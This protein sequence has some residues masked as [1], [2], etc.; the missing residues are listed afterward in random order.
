[1]TTW[2][3]ASLRFDDVERRAFFGWAV[4]VT[5]LAHAACASRANDE[6]DRVTTRC[7]AIVGGR[8]ATVA[9]Q[10]SAVAVTDIDGTQV[11]TGVLIAPTV[12]VT[13]AHCTVLQDSSTGEVIADLEPEDLSVVAG[14]LT[15]ADVRVDQIFEIRKIVTHPQFTGTIGEPSPEGLGNAHDIALLLLARPVIALQPTAIPSLGMVDAVLAGRPTLTIMGYGAT[16]PSG[17]RVGTLQIGNTTY[18]GRDESEFVAGGAGDAD[19]CAGDSGGPAYSVVEEPWLIGI[20]VRGRPPLEQGCGGGGVYTLLPA[21]S[22]WL[23]QNANGEYSPPSTDRASRTPDTGCE[24]MSARTV[25][26][27]H[28][29]RDAWLVAL[30]LVAWRRR[31]ARTGPAP[32]DRR[33]GRA[34]LHALGIR[35]RNQDRWVDGQGHASVRRRWSTFHR[36]AA[37]EIERRLRGPVTRETCAARVRYARASTAVGDGDARPSV[38][39]AVK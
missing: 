24:V 25:A 30:G 23:E 1:M 7:S 22:T 39:G 6:N 13:A 37:D 27:A 11:C 17:A 28:N 35:P 16:D 29:L 4:V 34:G 38:G 32:R 31:V 12:V 14:A 21:F 9:E 19:A 10:L 26:G 36:V 2:A 15:S 20:A 3:A 5:L 8:P 33:D 18:G